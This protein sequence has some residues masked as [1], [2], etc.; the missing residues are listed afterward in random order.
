MYEPAFANDIVPGENN[1]EMEE[2]KMVL[3]KALQDM[4]PSNFD[5]EIDNFLD[6]ILADDYADMP[7][8]PEM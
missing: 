4:L 2:D 1:E 3:P 5:D 7:L 6:E 8:F